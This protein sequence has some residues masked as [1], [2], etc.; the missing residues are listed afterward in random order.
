M[1]LTLNVA[2]EVLFIYKTTC[3][4]IHLSILINPPFLS[5]LAIMIYCIQNM[6]IVI[7]CLFW[8]TV[9]YLSLPLDPPCKH[10]VINSISSNNVFTAEYS[11]TMVIYL[12]TSR[13]NS[14][15]IVEEVVW[16]GDSCSL[17]GFPRSEPYNCI[18]LTATDEEEMFE[19]VLSQYIGICSNTSIFISTGTK[20]PDTQ[21][22]YQYQY[23][24]QYVIVKRGKTVSFMFN[25]CIQIERK[26]Y[27][28]ILSDLKF[29]NSVC[30]AIYQDQPVT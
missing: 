22:W 25:K 17:I 14:E 2:N 30:H 29:C 23:F 13:L 24:I 10:N 9:S 16:K 20:C 15:C 5:Y 6:H 18:S 1:G 8:F 4:H 28:Y 12:R 26:F 27:L 3:K 21:N 7:Y 11:M 19:V